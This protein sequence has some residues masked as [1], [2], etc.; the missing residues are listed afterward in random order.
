[1]SNIFL[2]KKCN[3]K[4]P[5]CFADEFVNKANEEITLENFNKALDFFKAS[6]VNHVG[7]IGG[8]PTLHSHFKEIIDILN[9][10][11]MINSYTIYTNGLEID[12][13]MEDILNE[14]AGMLVNCNPPY[15][16]GT[17]RYKNLKENIAV[18]TEKKKDKFTLGINLYSKDMDYSYIFDLLKITGHHHVRFSTA[19]PNIAKEKTHNILDSFKEMKPL[20]FGFFADCL[21]NEIVPNNDCNSFP[22]CIYT[23]EDKKLLLNLSVLANKYNMGIGTL[24]TCHTCSP[25]IDI[26]PDLMAVRCFGLSTYMKKSITEFKNLENLNLYFYN[27]IDLFARLSYVNKE[28]ED[29]K[30]RLLDKCGVCFTYKIHNIDNLKEVVSTSCKEAQVN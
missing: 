5:Y 16:I 2:T 29:C 8:E 6:R 30:M 18:L 27:K 28:C 3:L 7:L 22:D 23:P 9:K 21:K 1:M 17:A 11:N 12:K 24:G 13:Y 26:L 14:K 25:V 4:C 10:D 15:D 19:L 20:I